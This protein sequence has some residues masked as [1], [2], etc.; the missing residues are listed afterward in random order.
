MHKLYA[1]QLAKAT[2][3]SG[4]VDLDLLGQLVSAAFEET[5]RDRRR[6]DR[7]ITLMV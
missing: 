7:S 4:K 5:D 6:V 1:K 3:Q 2:N